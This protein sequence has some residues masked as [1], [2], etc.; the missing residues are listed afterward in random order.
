LFC[1]KFKI[2]EEKTITKNTEKTE[3]STRTWTNGPEEIYIYEL[4]KKPMKKKTH[5]FTKK[6]STTKKKSKPARI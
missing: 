4:N 6:K 5:K 2:Q 3:E 1:Y